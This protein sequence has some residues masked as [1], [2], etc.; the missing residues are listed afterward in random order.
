MKTNP[1]YY[2]LRCY[3]QTGFPKFIDAFGTLAVA[4]KW[5][6]QALKDG[7]VTVEILRDQP[8]KI[9]YF[10]AERDLVDT[11]TASH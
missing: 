5:A 7:Y 6:A 9:G 2:S 10:G 8:N 1:R 11:V 4:R 3:A